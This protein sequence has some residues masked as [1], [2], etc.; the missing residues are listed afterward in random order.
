MA[1]LCHWKTAFQAKAQFVT[2]I[3]WTLVQ[4]QVESDGPKN[5]SINFFASENMTGIRED[6]RAVASLRQRASRQTCPTEG[7]YKI[8]GEI[9]VIAQ[10]IKFPA[11]GWSRI[12]ITIS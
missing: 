6:A 2:S 10:V 11:D 12:V 1:L 7:R 9:V 3:T 5:N 4:A 8:N